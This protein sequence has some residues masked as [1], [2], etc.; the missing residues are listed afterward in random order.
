LVF[1]FSRRYRTVEL[2]VVPDA[3]R[4]ATVSRRCRNSRMPPC[5]S[6][7]TIGEAVEVT[8]AFASNGISTAPELQREPSWPDLNP[9][10]SDW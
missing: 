3:S 4:S 1:A 5:T 10:I 8:V 9:V 6:G 7:W 2:S